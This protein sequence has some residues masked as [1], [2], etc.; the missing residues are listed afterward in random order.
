MFKVV[1]LVGLL[2]IF[3]TILFA[4]S[5]V[6]LSTYYPAPWGAYDRLKLVPRSSL[7]LDSHCSELNNLGTMY[8]D[9]GLEL[10][11]EGVY[12]CQR[13]SEDSMAW[14]PMSGRYYVREENE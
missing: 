10:L 11:P 3:S 13:V 12:V 14:V 9:S 2:I 4:E 7:P 1:A 6:R 8:Y 5:V